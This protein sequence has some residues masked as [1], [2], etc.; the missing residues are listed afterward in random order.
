M[1]PIQPP[2]NSLVLTNRHTGEVLA[3]RRFMRDGR[4]SLAL[5]GTLPARSQGPPLH[6]HHRELESGTIVAGT[7]SAMVDG[8]MV[9]L[10]A[11][12]S[13]SFPSGVAHRWWNDADDL[14]VFAGEVS[15]VIDLDRYLQA[16]FEVLNSGPADRPPLFY[17]AHVGWRH[18]RTQ[19]VLFMP[20]PLQ[21]LVLPLVVAVGTLLGRY[22][23]TDWPGAP[24]RC[25]DAPVV[26]GTSV[27]SG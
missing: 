24:S 8:R 23:G 19:T 15:P 20:R 26:S 22:R 5:W 13:A 3:L 25:S 10:A 17:M 27:T 7:L 4:P 1:L 18:R 21:K 2:A 9:Q 11:G 12:Q 16:V 6:I 14:L